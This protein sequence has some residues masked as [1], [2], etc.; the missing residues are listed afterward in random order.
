[1]K[2]IIYSIIFIL[3]I[4]IF[5]LGSTF[6]YLSDTEVSENN[7][8]QAGGLDIKIDSEAHY[9]ELV[10]VDEFWSNPNEIECEDT[11]VVKTQNTK[12]G[13]FFSEDMF[14]LSRVFSSRDCQDFGF[15][16]TLA[17][18]E[19]EDGKY[20]PEGDANGTSLEGDAQKAYWTSES[21]VLGVIR[22]AAR[23]FTVLE[24]GY[25]GSVEE[26]CFEK[27]GEEAC[28]D[29]S[30]IEFCGNKNPECGNG[31]IEEG[32][33]CD[34][35][36]LID[37][38]GCD[39]NCDN[40]CVI[41]GQVE[42]APHAVYLHN[43]QNV[44]KK[45]QHSDND[46]A[47]QSV[48]SEQFIYFSWQFDNL[49]VNI[50]ITLAELS[51][52]HRED[53]VAMEVEWHD[54]SGWIQVCDPDESEV[55]TV[56]VCDLRP[57][58]TNTDQAD[59]IGFRLRLTKTGNCHEKFDWAQLKL[60]WYKEDN[61]GECGNCILESGEECDNSLNT[62]DGF[63]CTDDCK[64]KPLDPCVGTWEV[65]DLESGVHK[66]FDLS[67]IKP[68]D[69]GEDT[70]SFHVNDNDAWARIAVDDVVD[71]EN[72]CSIAEYFDEEN[73]DHDNDG[74]LQE[75]IY[76]YAWLDEGAMPGFQNTLLE[77]GDQGY[78]WEEGDN[79][80]QAN[81]LLFRDTALL[82]PSGEEWDLSPVLLA[83]YNENC[84]TPDSSPNGRNENGECHG[85]A[86]D[87]RFVGETTYYLGLAWEFPPF[88]GNST[89][90]DQFFFDLS[91]EVEQW[92]HNVDPF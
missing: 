9:R 37:G 73:C 90:S 60:R 40:E 6:A 56:D 57:F 83:A 46:Y 24:G 80:K 84:N 71:F 79:I 18:W 19:L 29:I 87:G 28:R 62:P 12:L 11:S 17:K 78:D 30:H 8:M 21:L 82:D 72:G 7:K 69:W 66:F 22:K 64:L 14:S 76:F 68:G 52:E 26:Y 74:E 49:P 55:D 86:E 44:S 85:L 89:Q 67:N 25:Q 34:D 47:I 81:E 58:I 38:D 43:S 39:A 54:G 2:K 70:I 42:E 77:E 48:S 35:G 20:I 61:C 92:R 27:R 65:T 16:F 50:P 5:T 51:I 13:T 59:V 32:E 88:G 31:I 1:M 91:F 15:D 53:G 41:Y 63:Y 10:C 4:S 45:L 36:N 75:N 33:E 3:S 23:N